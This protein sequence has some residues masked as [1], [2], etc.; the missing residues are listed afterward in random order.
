MRGAQ[1]HAVPGRLRRVAPRDRRQRGAAAVRQPE[2][3]CRAER[4]Q[5]TG[6]WSAAVWLE[7]LREAAGETTNLL[8]LDGPDSF[9][10]DGV[11][12]PHPLRV[13]PRTGDH[14]PAYATA[15]GK[16]LLAELPPEAVRMRY[17][18]GLERLTAATLPD[19]EALLTDLLVCRQRGYALNLEESVGDVHGV[20][21][22]VR[23]RAGACI[24]AVTVSAPS[25]RLGPSRVDEV[26]PLLVRAAAAVSA[27]L[28]A[29]RPPGPRLPDPVAPEG[30]PDTPEAR[31]GT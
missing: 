15:G 11:D 9:F 7:E 6:G 2:G 18:R 20:G 10:L 22:P 30:P 12:G 5:S 16:A 26:A 4:R 19:V 31:S 8:V 27:R 14:V 13:A 21:A 24:A 25:T 1:R 17:P 3:E 29:H 28:R 23:D